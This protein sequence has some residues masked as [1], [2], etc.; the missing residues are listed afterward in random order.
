MF[1]SM[2]AHK[3]MKNI[4]WISSVL[5]VIT[6]KTEYSQALARFFLLLALTVYYTFAAH[7][8][9]LLYISMG[10]LGFAAVWFGWV[11]YVPKLN[12]RKYFSLIF[13]IF[14]ISVALYYSGPE[15][16][17]VFL[18]FSWVILGYGYR[19]GATF[20]IY[21]SVLSGIFLL[22]VL[23]FS[24]SW[25]SHMPHTFE[26]LFVFFLVMLFKYRIVSNLEAETKARTKYQRR[27]YRYENK[28]MRD[29]LT[30][31]CNREYAVSWLSHKVKHNS[32]V[33]VLFLDLDNFKEFN[34][35]Y[36]HHVG[37][38]VLINISKRLVNCVREQDVV[39]RYAG[40]EFIIL[41]NDEDED[42]IN[43][44]ANR[45]TESLNKSVELDDGQRLTVTASIGI[46]LLGIHGHTPTEVLRHA[47]TAMYLAKRKGRNRVAWYEEKVKDETI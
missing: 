5:D 11:K 10:Y 34:D 7:H 18:L 2:E 12:L 36:G 22:N 40:D 44:I 4:T 28:A 21:A 3:S 9:E 35:N 15:H 14:A 45:V 25:T 20:V 24:P 27:A 39:C 8:D 42:T 43:E 16:L 31:L 38:N 19:Y 47:D 6:K 46:S 30:N 33:G 32:R 29:T 41:V 26:I 37:D 1:V 17:G 13:D 23:M